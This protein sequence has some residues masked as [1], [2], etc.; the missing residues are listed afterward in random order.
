MFQ[1]YFLAI[2]KVRQQLGW[3]INIG[4]ICLLHFTLLIRLLRAPIVDR[5]RSTFS[6]FTP[7]FLS[8]WDQNAWNLLWRWWFVHLSL[9]WIPFRVITVCFLLKNRLRFQYKHCIAMNEPWLL[10]VLQH[11]CLLLSPTLVL[12]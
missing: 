9:Q 10:P 11:G 2:R 3:C 5:N 8:V 12:P 1:S 6:Q 7:R 4:K